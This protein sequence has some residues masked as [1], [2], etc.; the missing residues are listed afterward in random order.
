MKQVNFRIYQKILSLL[1]G[2]FL[3]MGVYAQ[4][5][6][7]KGHVKDASGEPVIG[8][9]IVEKSNSTNGTITDLNGNFTLKTA[10]NAVLTVTF[11]GYKE[12]E[13]KAAPSL[14]VTLQDDAILLQEAVV[15]GYGTVKKN[16]LTGSVATV[17][18][19]QINKGLASSPSDLLRGK[20][21]G[22]VITSGS[23]QPGSGATIR[24]RGGSSLSATN[25][26]LIVVDG[27]PLGNEGIQGMADPLSSI[28][29][30]DIESF[31]VLKDASATAIYGSRASNGVIVI[32]TKKG[33]TGGSALPK[34]DLDFSTSLS[35]IPKYVDVMSADLLRKSVADY[36]GINSDAYKALGNANTDW[37]KE[38]YR[39]AQ[40]YETN[41]S[42]N[43]QVG[44]GN[45]G[46]LPY[47]LSGGFLSEEGIL[48]KS[49]M[50]RGTLSLNLA[51]QLLNKHLII[52]L[53]GK[54]VLTDNTF[55][56]QGAIGAAIHMDPTQSVYDDSSKGNHGYYMWRDL[57]GNVNTMATQ[58]PVALIKEKDDT[59]IARRFIGNAQFD[60][61]LHGFEDLRFNLNLGL[62][63]SKSRGTVNTPAGSEQ[64]LHSTLESGSGYHSDYNYMRRDQTLESYFNYSHVFGVHHVDAMAGYSWQH[65][66]NSSNSLAVKQDDRTSKLSESIFKTEYYLVSFFGRA[67]YVYSDKYLFTFTLRRDGT[68]RFQNNKWGT[69]PSVAL[70]WNI[71]NE[72]FLKE[73]KVLSNLK[74]RLSWGETGQQ[75]LNAGNYPT[76]A[77]YYTNQLG[78]YYYFGNQLITPIT[79]LGYNANLKWETT[80]T[81]NAGLDYGFLNGRISGG[82]DFY[83][84]KTKD[85]INYIPVSALSNLK[86]YLT[87]NIGNLEN[88]GLEF[89]VNAIP[90]ETKDWH[91]NIGANIAWN[92]N[93]IT[94]LTAVKSD[95]TG[96]ETGG[97]SGGVGNNVQM[98]QVGH[99][100]SSYY[101][102]EQIYDKDGRPIEGAYVDRNKDGKINSDDKYLVHKPAPDVTM[103][104]NTTVN[105]KNW[106]LAASAHANIGNWV[107][108][109]VSSDNEM[110]ADLWTNNFV[111][112][113]ME[114]AVHTNFDQ[115][116]YLSDYYLHNASF[117]KLDNVTLGYTFRN[118]IKAKDRSLN[119]NLFL[120]VQNVFTISKYKG[121]DPEIFNGIDNNLYPRPRI[122][123]LGAK[124]NF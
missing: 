46:Q 70:G 43:G 59:S 54:G 105:Y 85:L 42:F 95:N 68:S 53:N 118:L 47:R 15:I 21:A 65:F 119:L 108:D 73:N 4:Q 122:F 33:T 1:L 2:L 9:N 28:N 89:E 93:K 116:Q 17:R 27:L 31:T 100:T 88:V 74:L 121:L 25:D 82:V 56:N 81:W 72:S 114:S 39:L 50:N 67:N 32:T 98:H 66:Y 97:I 35:Q 52:N 107:Y 5:I 44:L 91:W 101:V 49:K 8:A 23:G 124:L 62:D 24:V 26:P 106:T 92:K 69:F 38:I 63:F 14:V 117:F 111:S 123:M 109:N 22:V 61:K 19:D 58:N 64:S 20:S 110:R 13:V 84:R 6:T 80:T 16:D 78:S 104:F 83:Y 112:N 29:P 79:A 51:P 11:I 30:N 48:E 55:A 57:S 87:S 18:A 60:Y 7:V 3:S 40:S 96:V 113:R 36:A 77:T 45:V 86:N 71:S 102:Y 90:I 75:D 37:Q 34:I 94:K 76:L 99:P 12:Q 41:L 10:N 103:G 115:A 120:T